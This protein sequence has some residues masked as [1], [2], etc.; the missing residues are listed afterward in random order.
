MGYKL[1]CCTDISGVWL[2]RLQF[3]VSFGCTF[4]AGGA[5]LG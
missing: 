1:I 5:E 2:D 3:C 4:F